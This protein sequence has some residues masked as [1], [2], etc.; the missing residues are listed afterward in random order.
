LETAGPYCASAASCSAMAQRR[1]ISRAKHSRSASASAAG[2]QL[3]IEL[4][5]SS[6]S[7]AAVRS[8]HGSAGAPRTRVSVGQFFADTLDEIGGGRLLQERRIATRSVNHDLSRLTLD[9]TDIRC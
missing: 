4:K 3:V 1:A 6:A 2:S 5:R 8:R 9:S 7:V